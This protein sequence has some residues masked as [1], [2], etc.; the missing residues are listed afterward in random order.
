MSNMQSTVKNH[1]YSVH[2]N[3]ILTTSLK[4][5]SFSDAIVSVPGTKK[6]IKCHR[7]VLS[8]SSSFLSSLLSHHEASDE[9]VHII[10]ADTDFNDLM[11]LL[12][13]VYVGQVSLSG[14]S[15]V[16]TRELAESVLGLKLIEEK[17]DKQIQ[18]SAQTEKD[19]R[20][21]QT[22]KVKATPQRI[23]S[24]RPLLI[25]ST[26]NQAPIVFIM[27]GIGQSYEKFG[28]SHQ[29]D[30]GS[31]NSYQKAKIR[32][33]DKF[34]CDICAK[35]FPLDC[36]L[37]RHLKTHFD[38]KSFKCR[39]CDKGFSSKSSLRHHVFIKHLDD[40]KSSI[41]QKSED[42]SLA[43]SKPFKV[44]DNSRHQK[45]ENIEIINV[46][47]GDHDLSKHVEVQMTEADSEEVEVSHHAGGG[48]SV[49]VAPGE[50]RSRGQEIVQKT[51]DSTNSSMY[52]WI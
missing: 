22:R 45:S 16:K 21:I 38:N 27:P 44:L 28:Q 42:I 2:M 19:M 23:A 49:I 18:E 43:N 30:P 9:Q 47:V 14:S 37:Q 17:I 33:A 26:D 52:Y 31:L 36:L 34:K 1:D 6:V 25:K 35:G 51:T 48:R 12:N 29:E 15:V 11:A 46:Q 20:T 3:E 24:K 8:K 4:R 5:G 7:T 40:T 10:V 50:A 13:I 41:T 39:H 32:C